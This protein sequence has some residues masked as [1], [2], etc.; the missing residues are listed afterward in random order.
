MLKTSLRY[1]VAVA[2]HGSIRAAC[3]ELNVAQ[4][5][6]SRQLQGLEREIG[7]VLLERRP[8]G[9]VLTQAGELLLRFGL[10][11]SSDRQALTTG[12]LAIRE[13]RSGHVSIAVI[14]SMV[15]RVLPATIRAFKLQYPCITFAVEVVTT[16]RAVARVRD[17]DAEIGIGFCP[18]LGSDL[19]VAHRSHEPLMAVMAP[20]HP[21]ASRQD[22]TAAD[23]AGF[24]LALSPA[25]N[26]AR[27]LFETACSAAGIRPVV[28]FE[29]NS[30]ELLRRYA[31]TGDGV[32]VLLKQTVA[33]SL[34]RQ[35]LVA[36][37][38]RDPGMGGT[39]DVFIGQRRTLP[40]AAE[41]FIA[42]LAKV[43]EDG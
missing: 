1:F 23:I 27:A 39:I 3:A 22:V 32:T 33:M 37:L 25:D 21:L 11:A 43:L 10:N 35:Q 13:L 14:Q 8:R 24:P 38:F 40:A 6:V 12:V 34:T 42:S 15:P 19:A 28:A 9:V 18:A 30:L 20:T 41:R 36:R 5:A 17:G 2:R 16:E 7:S 26:P 29:S 4:S 31:E